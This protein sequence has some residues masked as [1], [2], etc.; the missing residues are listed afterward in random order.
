[1]VPTI[2]KEE[3]NNRLNTNHRFHLVDVLEPED[4]EQHH[5]KGAI[6]IPY[7]RIG[8]VAEDK[9]DKGEEI[10]VYCSDYD[11]TSSLIAARK[12]QQL[13]YHNIYRYAGGKKE[14]MESNMPIEK[15]S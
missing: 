1:M 10:I 8:Y 12:L 7:Q 3:L 11:C 13:G 5:I 4:Y 6:N 9:F 15:G 2:S 14:W